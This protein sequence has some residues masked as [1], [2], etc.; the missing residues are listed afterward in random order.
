MPAPAGST[1]AIES[2]LAAEAPP[3]ASSRERLPEEAPRSSRGGEASMFTGNLRLFGLPDLLE[4]L[5]GGQRTG[6]LVCSS[7]HGHGTIYLRS[8]KVTGASSPGT[9]SLGEYLVSNGAVSSEDARAVM[10]IQQETQ[11]RP[12]IGGVLVRSGLASVGQVREALSM[13][14]RDALGELMKWVDG[15]FAFDADH[16]IDASPLD[17]DLEFD[18]QAILLEIYK[19][20]DE[21]SLA[22]R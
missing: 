5:R 4:F 11:P 7:R 8:G 20:L 21:G 22:A 19:E 6:T 12:R 9:R 3:P 10:Q 17:V 18:P 1:A 15:E 2:Q 16:T 13:Q 14:I